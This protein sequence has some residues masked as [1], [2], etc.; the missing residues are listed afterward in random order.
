MHLYTY[1]LLVGR[2]LVTSDPISP[3]ISHGGIVYVQ[4]NS[5]HTKSTGARTTADI[6]V[7]H[8][9]ANSFMHP[10]YRHEACV[11]AK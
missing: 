9:L 6:C 5:S 1:V 2:W 7:C 3:H 8:A 4:L 11:I 10:Q